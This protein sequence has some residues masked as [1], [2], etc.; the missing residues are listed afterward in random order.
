MVFGNCRHASPLPRSGRRHTMRAACPGEPISVPDQR[1]WPANRIIALVP[2][3]AF[4][5]AA[6]AFTIFLLVERQRSPEL[7]HV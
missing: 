2:I 3:Q 7:R 1:H 6:I 5:A 4:G